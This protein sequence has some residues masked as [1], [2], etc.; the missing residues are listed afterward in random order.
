[1][2]IFAPLAIHKDLSSQLL[3]SLNE[4]K[5]EVWIKSMT[6]MGLMLIVENVDGC[7]KTL[8][9]REMFYQREGKIQ[10][11]E[12]H[13]SLIHRLFLR[14]SYS[15]QAASDNSFTV[16]YLI[17]SCGFPPDKAISASKRLN[18]QTPDRAD[19]VIAF[20]KNQ[21]FTETQISHLLR[22]FPRA[23]ACNPQINLFPK[24]EFLRSVGLS[25]S[26]IVKIL[27]ARPKSLCKSLKNSIEPTFNLLRDLL[28]SNEKTLL[29]IRRCAWVLDLDSRANVIPN[30]QLLRDVG[31]PGSKLLYVLT[32]H[33]RD[34]SDT[35]EQFKKAVEEVMEM[36]FDPLKTN[37]LSGVHAVRS[38]N[39]SNWEKKMETYEKWGLS[40]AQILLAFRTNPWCM[41]KSEEKINKVMDCLVNKMGFEASIVANNSVLISLSMTKRII[42]RCLVYQYCLDN[43]LIEGKNE[44]G[45]CWWLKSS[46]NIFMKRLERYETKAPGVLQFY[47]E[48]LN[49]EN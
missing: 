45:F 2:E 8:Q 6:F 7:Y 12:S 27:V 23:L 28:Q 35:K 30:M 42:P 41:M 38:M 33:P 15:S 48:K 3:K 47:Q 24:F 19:S 11:S 43:G 49:H 34:I 32:N 29:A 13:V 36:G 40:K 1:M 31:M 4:E 37:F 10:N 39:K 18:I 44:C 14:T 46:D 17:D 5:V 16:S 9:I 26:D 25:D 20:F 21:G 22:K